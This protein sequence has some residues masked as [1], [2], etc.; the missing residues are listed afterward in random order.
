MGYVRDPHLAAL[1]AYRRAMS[2][3]QVHSA[4]AWINHWE[5]PE[6]LR[7]HREFD[8]YWRGAAEAAKKLGYDAVLL[9]PPYYSLQTQTELLALEEPGA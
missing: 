9:P 1:A 4:I 2:P 6:R 5:Q 3:V 7:K 8:L